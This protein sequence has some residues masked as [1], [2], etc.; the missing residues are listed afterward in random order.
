MRILLLL[1]ELFLVGC[2]ASSH[3][4]QLTTLSAHGEVAVHSWK[5]LRDAHVIKQDRDYSCGAAS[6]A[7]L[8]NEFTVCR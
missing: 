2:A 5:A 8:L 6:L 4:A 7:T 1:I 3:A